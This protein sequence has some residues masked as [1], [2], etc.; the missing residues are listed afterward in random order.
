[1]GLQVG[2]PL[3]ERD[4][5]VLDD[6]L[7]PRHDGGVADGGVKDDPPVHELVILGDARTRRY[8]E[9]PMRTA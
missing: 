5:V 7:S 1:M 8:A 3:L 4:L 2:T 6:H 9:F